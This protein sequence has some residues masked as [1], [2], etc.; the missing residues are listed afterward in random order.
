MLFFPYSCVDPL[1]VFDP[2]LKCQSGGLWILPPYSVVEVVS[3]TLTDEVDFITLRLPGGERERCLKI[4]KLK[5]GASVVSWVPE[6]L[7]YWRPE[8]VGKKQHE[9]KHKEQI[10]TEAIARL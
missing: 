4:I 1:P 7:K 5:A 9:P 3:A 2:K 10:M 6:I 8:K